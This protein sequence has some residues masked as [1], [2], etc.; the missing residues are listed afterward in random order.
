MKIKRNITIDNEILEKLKELSKLEDR[1]VSNLI[2]KIL[3][4]YFEQKKEPI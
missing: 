1:N 3:K 4:D 2:N